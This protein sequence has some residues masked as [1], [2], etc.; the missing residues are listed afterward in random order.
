MF[1][2][3]EG[4]D[5]EEVEKVKEV[6]NL[7]D[8]ETEPLSEKFIAKYQ[9]LQAKGTIPEDKLFRAAVDAMELDGIRLLT[10]SEVVPAQAPEEPE[11][12][13]HRRPHVTL[14]ELFSKDGSSEK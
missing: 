1:F 5:S 7:M 9:Q 13:S 2:P 14:K 10:A 12:S 4:A 11:K 8:N 6:F 3:H